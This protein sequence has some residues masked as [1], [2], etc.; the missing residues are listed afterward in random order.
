MTQEECQFTAKRSRVG[1]V[2]RPAT[3]LRQYR[4]PSLP[5][6]PAWGIFI[7]DHG[8]EPAFDWKEAGASLW[9]AKWELLLPVVA[10]VAL[11]GG[12]ATPVEA[13]AA[14]AFYAFLETVIYR[15]LKLTRDVPRVMA[16]C[17][18]LI[19]GVLLILGVA[20]GFANYLITSEITTYAAEWTTGTIKSPWVFLLVLYLFLLI[21]GCL[22]DIYSAIIVQVPILV[23]IG[24]A[25]GIDPIHLGI[26]FLANL[27][28]GYLTPPVG[29]NLFLSSYRFNKPLP[30]VVRS[31]VPIVLVLGAGVLLITYTPALTTILPRWFGR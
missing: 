4:S 29:L 12:F 6:E 23:P 1:A 10:V 9:E 30:E 3:I 19:G 26:V 7:Q 2:P 11:F 27:E 17:G 22:M 24:K 5:V 25:Y 28:L 21:V 15:D 8:S 13:A 18:L 14:T 16:E 20:L 31:V